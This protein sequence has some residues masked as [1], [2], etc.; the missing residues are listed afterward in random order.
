MLE[1][2][3]KCLLCIVWTAGNGLNPSGQVWTAGKP[4][5]NWSSE[6]GNASEMTGKNV[7]LM[8]EKL[9]ALEMPSVR[10]RHGAMPADDVRNRKTLG[11]SGFMLRSGKFSEMLAAWGL[12]LFL[13]VA[14]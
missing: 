1:A 10:A 9:E 4:T 7:L 14:F 8:W 11:A 12:L 6:A 5:N 2:G 13:V 3:L